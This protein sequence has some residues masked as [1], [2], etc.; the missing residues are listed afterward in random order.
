MWGRRWEAKDVR[1][2]EHEKRGQKRR[3]TVPHA[4]LT[5]TS[6]PI[7]AGSETFAMFGGMRSNKPN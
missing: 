5:P 7:R 3:P 2:E 1:M 4:L 6:S